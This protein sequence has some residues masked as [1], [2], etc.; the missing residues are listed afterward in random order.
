MKQISIAND[1]IPVGEFK[2]GLAKWLKSVHDSGRPLVI[3]QNGRPAGV[4]L[5]PEAFDQLGY[6]KRFK[7][8][9]QRGLGDAEAQRVFDASQ[10]K[11][12]LQKRRSSKVAK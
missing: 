10:L 3:T 1:I 9:V 7:E 8:S 2:T 12:E 5:A 4:L 6:S 11:Q